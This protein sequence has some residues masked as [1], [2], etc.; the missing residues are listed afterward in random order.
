MRASGYFPRRRPP[1][2][3]NMVVAA[4]SAVLVEIDRKLIN[5]AEPKPFVQST[6]TTFTIRAATDWNAVFVGLIEG[7]GGQG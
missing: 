4:R 2:Q 6:G 3:K 1:H 5:L 7:P